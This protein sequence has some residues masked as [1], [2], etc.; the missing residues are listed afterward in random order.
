MRSALSTSIGAL[1]LVACSASPYGHSRI[2]EPLGPEGAAE[3]G[4]ENLDPVMAKRAPDDWRQKKVTLFG[5]VKKRDDG[6]GGQA[7]VTLSLRNRASR[8]L[9]ETADEDSCRTTVTAQ[10]FDV[11]YARIRLTDPT[12]DLGEHSVGTG[13]LVR[14]IG[15]IAKETDP[16]DGALVVDA[17]YYRHWPRGSY[18]TDAAAS[19]LR[20]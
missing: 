13:S 15:T 14:V 11:V 3:Q 17:S 18:V 20:R 4:A 12:D 7:Y 5:V 10:E 8:N 9:C 2:Y 6:P 1:A 19:A 16:G